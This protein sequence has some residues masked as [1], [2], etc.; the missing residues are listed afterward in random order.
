MFAASQNEI[1]RYSRLQIC[2]TIGR[3]SREL[4]AFALGMN[5][6]RQSGKFDMHAINNLREEV[7]KDQW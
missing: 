3:L 5:R 2:A 1:L 7:A 6:N 4:D